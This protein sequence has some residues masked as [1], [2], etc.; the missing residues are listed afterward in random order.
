MK[1]YTVLDLMQ[2]PLEELVLEQLSEAP[3]NGVQ[4][5]IYY[6]TVTNNIEYYNK[7]AR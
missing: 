3:S 1:V 2:N 6:N 4:G 7:N 5:Q